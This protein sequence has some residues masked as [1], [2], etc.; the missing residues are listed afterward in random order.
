MIQATERS[1]DPARTTWVMLDGPALLESWTQ[2]CA[3]EYGR[4]DAA[5]RQPWASLAEVH[6]R[7]HWSHCLQERDRQGFSAPASPLPDVLPLLQLAQRPGA[8]L[9]GKELLQ[10]LRIVEEQGRYADYLQAVSDDLQHWAATVGPDAILLQTLARA[11][12][13]D[14]VL[15]D[16]ASPELG[17][18]RQE[19]R[20]ARDALQQQLNA[21]LRDPR[22]RD[23]W[24]D[25][26]VVQRSGRFLLPLKVQYK[27]RFS[28]IIHDRSASGGTLF[29]E[30]L[31]AVDANNRL[32]EV[33]RALQE[34]QERIL[35][36]LTWRVGRA[37]DAIRAALLLMGRIEA[38]RAGLEL[39][40]AWNGELLP[41]MGQPQFDLR[42]LRH[43]LLA[44]RHPEAVV[45]NALALGQD[46][47]QLVITGPNAGGKTAL[48]KALGLCHLLAYL[49]L[50]V[51]ARGQLGYF[52]QILAVIG[53][54]QDIQ[55]DLSTFSAQLERLRRVLLQ[56]DANSLL[57]LDE[58]GNGTDPRE[59]AALARAIGSELLERGALAVLT[60]HM[61][62]LKRYALERPEIVLGGMGFDVQAL[63]PTYRLQLGMGGASHGL[64]IA[65]RLGLPAAV[66]DRAEAIH[67][68][69]QEDW[70]LWEARRESLLQEAQ[71]ER[72]E[73]EALRAEAERLQARWR[74]EQELA[75]AA[76]ERAAAE[77]RHQWETILA[78]ARAEVRAAIAA[79]KAGRDTAAATARLDALDERLRP[80][81]TQAPAR[82]PTAGDRGLFLPL[83]QAVEVLRVDG[84]GQ[85]LQIEIRGK[86][87]WVPLEQ[88][89][90]DPGATLAEER[91]G[92]HYRS[93]ESHPWR[94]DLRGQRRDVAR[95]ALERHVDGAIAAGR[96]QVE[97]LHGT[98]NGVLAEM[99]REFAQ[100]DAR[101][102]AWRMARPE[103]G[104]GGVSELDLR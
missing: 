8:L 84:P 1:P 24:Q 97:V 34:E 22:W 30:P 27:G 12:D 103:Q 15:L 66:L 58:L 96:Q 67:A 56:A 43:P 65:R 6:E 35:K 73:A 10:I 13:A 74:K 20:R 45:G 102:L 42:D 2:R 49:G 39:A 101:V 46:H 40:A 95:V 47:R 38:T 98:G 18:L 23:F 89:Q 99:V 37:A 71:R 29:V 52:T 11:L 25:P 32:W 7:L 21:T 60:S 57:L 4:R 5:G 62:A 79:L 28:A 31:D 70:E 44:L 91:G 87:L 16:G 86:Q 63:R 41:V 54:A 83:R 51:P 68:S 82:L 72:Q 78:Q 81:A 92:S 94:L 61:E 80:A 76:R 59:G 69:E 64:A 3:H 100:S 77:A 48:L 88:F 9:S 90:L 17:R 36:E 75:T 104:G 33:E 93:P 50:P 53:D 26:V 19:L 85:K 14:G 55:A